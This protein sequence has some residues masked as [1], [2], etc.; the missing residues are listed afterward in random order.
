MIKRK[1]LHLLILILLQQAFYPAFSQK[2][3]HSADTLKLKDF[4]PVSIYK[5]PQTKVE[6]AKYPVIDFHSHDDNKSPEEIKAWVE[7]MDAMGISKSMILS[8]ATGA[9]FDSV[10]DKYAPYKDRFEVW[11]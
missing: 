4:K 5:I 8:Y 9:R 6:K 3:D 7:T 1:S 2:G 11:C 10:V